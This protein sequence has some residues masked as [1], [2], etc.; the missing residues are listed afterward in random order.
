[1]AHHETEPSTCSSKESSVLHTSNLSQWGWVR[2]YQFPAH[3][4][5]TR[6]IYALLVA[7]VG[8]AGRGCPHLRTVTFPNKKIHLAHTLREVSWEG[9]R[10]RWTLILLK[11]LLL[12]EHVRKFVLVICSYVCTHR[13]YL[14]LFLKCLQ[15]KMCASYCSL[16]C[17]QFTLALED[18]LCLTS[19]DDEFCCSYS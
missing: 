9:G 15:L 11:G 16:V 6:K 19:F 13:F 2:V 4:K 14:H 18:T 7:A 8:A 17:L 3:S 10:T 12:P 1:M 5:T